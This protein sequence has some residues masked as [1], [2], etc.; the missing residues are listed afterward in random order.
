[1]SSIVFTF[2]TSVDTQFIVVCDCNNATAKKL[3]DSSIFSLH[4]L[5]MQ[6]RVSSFEAV[7]H[8]SHVFPCSPEQIQYSAHET[9]ASLLISL[10]DKN[11]L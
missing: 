1:M 4:K 5:Y 6:K 7:A 2:G 11:L 3:E 10:N 8:H 9:T